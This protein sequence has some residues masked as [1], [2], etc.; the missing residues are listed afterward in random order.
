MNLIM[1]KNIFQ[2]LQERHKQTI[3]SIRA[4]FLQIK[5]RKLFSVILSPLNRKKSSKDICECV[6]DLIVQ[7]MEGG[8]HSREAR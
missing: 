5:T 7:Y 2:K 4:S 1:K 6:I 3:H 8:I